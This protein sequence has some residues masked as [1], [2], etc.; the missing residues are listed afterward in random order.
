MDADFQINRELNRMIDGVT[1]KSA[2]RQSRM[3]SL[4]LCIMYGKL[5]EE[6]GKMLQMELSVRTGNPQAAEFAI[7]P[8]AEEMEAAV[9]D[10]ACLLKERIGYGALPECKRLYIAFFFMADK[11]DAADVKKCFWI[12]AGLMRRLGYKGEYEVCYYCIYDYEKMADEKKY[13]RAVQDLLRNT[14]TSF[15]IG[16]F[17]QTRDVTAG[18]RYMRAVQAMA[19]HIFLKCIQEGLEDYAMFTVAFWKKDVLKSSI[20]DY[21][22]QSLEMQERK[23]EEDTAY[24]RRIGQVIDQITDFPVEEY[25][26]IFKCFPVCTDNLKKGW[27]EPGE[28]SKLLYG[29]KDAFREFLAENVGG[30]CEQS[31]V[32]RFLEENIGNLYAV[33]KQL[34]KALQEYKK[35]KERQM[36]EQG[37]SPEQPIKISATLKIREILDG[38][39]LNSWE[40]EG[41]RFLLEYKIK[42]VEAVLNYLCSDQ[43]KDTL[44]E[45]EKETETQMNHLRLIRREFFS[46]K[47][48]ESYAAVFCK[49]TE[50]PGAAWNQVI[51]SEGGL[52]QIEEML[53]QL[54]DQ[55]LKQISLNQSLI[56]AEYV[57]HLRELRRTEAPHSYYAARLDTLKEAREAEFLYVG[58][59]SKKINFGD[60]LTLSRTYLPKVEIRSR[61]WEPDTCLEFFAVREITDLSELYAIDD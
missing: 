14:D 27:Y 3:K 13:Q 36:R 28:L 17:T 39:R 32:E 18:E 38:L 54:Y 42:Y 49:D 60:L 5:P 16:I 51:W 55:V 61:E 43:F 29:T 30:L 50:P 57:K 12:L 37:E 52:Q 20:V 59:I 41:K 48:S 45:M 21:L 47:E 22:M 44:R 1:K 24:N 2:V 10:S 56:V 40:Q 25:S 11:L 9:T 58:S 4:P 8:C 15:P 33:R 26:G 35:D 7:V 31:C 46:R 34:D 19:M 23:Q 6:I 53:T